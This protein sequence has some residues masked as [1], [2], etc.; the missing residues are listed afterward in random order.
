MAFKVNGVP[1]GDLNKMLWDNYKIYIR[2][3]VHEEIDWDVNRT[4]LHVM[5]TSQQVDKLLG[6]IKEISRQKGI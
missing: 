5:V 3:V 6:A 1:S 4:S 2:S